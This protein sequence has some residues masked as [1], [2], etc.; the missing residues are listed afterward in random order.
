VTLQG[1]HLTHDLDF[2]L[3]LDKVSNQQ[4]EVKSIYAGDTVKNLVQEIC[5]SRLVQEI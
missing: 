4:V 1:L 5:T 3:D 2:I